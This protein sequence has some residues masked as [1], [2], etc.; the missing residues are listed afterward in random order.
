MLKCSQ[1]RQYYVPGF[2][3][4]QC[5]AAPQADPAD[6]AGLD[7]RGAPAAPR[8]RLLPPPEVKPDPPALLERQIRGRPIRF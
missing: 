2:L 8:P 7:V 1:C 6:G 3:D 4:C 5:R